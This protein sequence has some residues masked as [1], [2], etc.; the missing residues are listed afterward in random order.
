MGFRDLGFRVLFVYSFQAM[1]A[2]KYQRLIHMGR[3]HSL[4]FRVRMGAKASQES[5]PKLGFSS[6]W[7][8]RIWAKALAWLKAQPLETLNT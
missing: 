6:S 2:I 7:K 1:A 4:G 3:T 5:S 8:Y